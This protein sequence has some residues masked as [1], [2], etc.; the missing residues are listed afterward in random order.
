VYVAYATQLAVQLRRVGRFSPLTAALFPVPLAFFLAVFAR[1][2]VRTF[3]RRR[4]TWRGRTIP[5]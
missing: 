4:V 2:L 5:T 3:V 1:S